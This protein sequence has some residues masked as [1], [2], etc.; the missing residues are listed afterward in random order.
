MPRKK[1]I[2]EE[3]SPKE[4]AKKSA[5][6]DFAIREA[7]HAGEPS[8]KFSVGDAVAV[9]NLRNCIV[10]EVCDDGRYYCIRSGN[11]MQD[12]GYWAW[13]SVRP[14]IARREA[15]FAQK[16]S[17]LV[18][19][20]FSNRSIESL[21]HMHYSFGID[22]DP[23]YQRGS[24]WD[25]TDRAKL[26]DSIF[27]GRSIGKFVLRRVPYDES[28]AKNCLYEVVDGKQ[29]L[30]TLT[31]FYENRFV[32]HGYTYNDLPQEDKN[33]L[34]S[35]MTSVLELPE[36]TTEKEVLEVFVAINQNGKPVD[37]AVIKH[38]KELL[39]EEK[40]NG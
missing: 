3:L 11:E 23:D 18:R 22:F 8:Y 34:K 33:W 17:P 16:D 5:S 21:I 37:D 38:A 13:T 12:Y 6:F 25:D 39:Q 2:V 15:V 24:V 26:L 29:R 14:V 31:A 28:L 32:Y 20:S 27:A 9:G 1:K 40:K 35:A 19:C 36:S 30:L 4:K 7:E 10:D